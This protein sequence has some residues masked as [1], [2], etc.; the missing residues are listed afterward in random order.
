[1]LKKVI[2]VETN[3]APDEDFIPEASTRESQQIS[4]D[5]I[6]DEEPEEKPKD[7]IV[8]KQLPII[9]ESLHSLKDSIL[10]TVRNA[11]SLTCTED[12]VKDVKKVRADLNAK[13]KQ[14]EDLR[15]VVK[16]QILA[17]YDAFEKVYK[18]CVSD[19]FKPADADLKRKIDEVEN[20][21]RDAKREKIRTFFNEY[22]DS[23]CLNPEFLNFDK[24]GMKVNLSDSE[25]TLKAWVKNYIDT[26]AAD[27]IAIRGMEF[28]DEIFAEYRVCMQLSSAVQQVND[29]HA[30]IER[31]RIARAEA[32]E[33]QEKLNAA[34]QKVQESINNAPAMEMPPQAISEPLEEKELPHVEFRVY[35]TIDQLKALKKFLNDGGYKYVNI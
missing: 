15:K 21:L 3:P 7:L 35:G 25:R 30:R 4:L 11:M 32:A 6:P 20:G 14:M 24:C 29:R 34:A 2:S 5:D 16:D 27:M 17:P 26:V 1:M 13:F 22:R 12:T 10:S 28:A 18:E 23:L 9:E 33:K 8:V 19:I 31:E